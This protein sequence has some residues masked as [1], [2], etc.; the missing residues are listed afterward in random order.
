MRSKCR[1]CWDDAIGD[2]E[3]QEDKGFTKNAGRCARVGVAGSD[4]IR[5]EQYG[6]Y[7]SVMEE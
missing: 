7:G 2:W 4:A 3:A 5:Q 1:V 6:E